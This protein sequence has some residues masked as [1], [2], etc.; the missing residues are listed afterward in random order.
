MSFV[1]AGPSLSARCGTN[2]LCPKIRDF[3]RK[4]STVRLLEARKH[5]TLRRREERARVP[6]LQSGA[7]GRRFRT[8]KAKQKFPVNLRKFS[9]N[10]RKKSSYGKFTGTPPP[11]GNPG[12]QNYRFPKQILHFQTLGR[13]GQSP[14]IRDFT[15]KCSA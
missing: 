2:V 1:L 7:G 6:E 15:E 5:S 13:E 10:L 4:C 3:P 14:E 12:L 8:K 11:P 9:V